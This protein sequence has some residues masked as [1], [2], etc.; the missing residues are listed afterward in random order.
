MAVRDEDFAMLPQC[1]HGVRRGPHDHMVIG[2]N[3][4]GVQHMIR[5]IAKEL[6]VAL[7]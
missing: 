7:G 5:V 2:R 3:E 1:G 6:R 4:I